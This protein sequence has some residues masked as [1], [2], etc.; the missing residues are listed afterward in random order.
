SRREISLRGNQP[1][2][3]RFEAKAV[4]ASTA[5]SST[6]T[7]PSEDLSTIDISEFSPAVLSIDGRPPFDEQGRA[8]HRFAMRVLET[9]IPEVDESLSQLNGAALIVGRNPVGLAL[10]DQIEALGRKAVVIPLADDI[11]KTM[12]SL[13]KIWQAYQPLHLFVVT[14]FDKE[15]TTELD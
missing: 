11:D 15:A 8:C 9:R 13:D 2:Q 6:A 5:T 7:D 10:R 1:S 14:P 4:R 12:A 3:Y